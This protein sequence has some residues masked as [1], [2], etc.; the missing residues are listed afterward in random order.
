[1]HVLLTATL[2][3]WSSDRKEYATKLLYEAL[4]F[5]SDIYLQ[6]LSIEA[7]QLLSGM[8]CKDPAQRLTVAQVLAHPWL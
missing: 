3:F 8:L 1:M 4:D 7:K 2:P 5:N 6:E